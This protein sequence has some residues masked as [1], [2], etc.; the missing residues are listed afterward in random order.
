LVKNPK[1]AMIEVK[2]KAMLP[3]AMKEAYKVQALETLAGQLT[4]HHPVWIMK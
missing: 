3:T 2:N 1:T 4:K